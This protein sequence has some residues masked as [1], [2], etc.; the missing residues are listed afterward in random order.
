MCIR[1]CAP[2][3]RNISHIRYTRFYA[4]ILRQARNATRQH[5]QRFRRCSARSIQRPHL[6]SSL[7]DAL[8][9]ARAKGARRATVAKQ[10]FLPSFLRSLCCM[11]AYAFR[12]TAKATEE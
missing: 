11:V 12:T 10:S 5:R 7:P 6:C 1:F 8:F 2:I 3:P 9:R 4:S